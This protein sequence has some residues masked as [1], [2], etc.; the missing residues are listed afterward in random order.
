MKRDDLF[1]SL[2]DQYNTFT[3]TIQDPEAFHHDVYEISYDAD[4]S[5]EFHEMLAARRSQR[6]RELNESLESL[7]VEIIANPKLM[8]TDQ[9]QHALQ[10]FQSKSFDSMIRFF[11]SYIP[12]DYLERRH[13]GQ[14]GRPVSTTSSFSEAASLRTASTTATSVDDHIA[15][16]PC[17]LDGFGTI[18]ADFTDE[19]LD[20]NAE[21]DDYAGQEPLSPPESEMAHSEASSD[22][23]LSCGYSSTNTPS[24]SMSFSGS[25]SGMFSPELIRRSLTHDD[26]DASSRADDCETVATSIMDSIEMKHELLS[27]QETEEENEEDDEDED[28]IPTTQFPEDD[29]DTLDFYDT[30]SA[31]IPTPKQEAIAI[32]DAAQKAL[33]SQRLASPRRRSPSPKPHC[34]PHP[35]HTHRRD[36]S[37]LHG[38]RRSPEEALSKVQK[39]SP[40]VA[41]RRPVGWRRMD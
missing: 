41:R 29:F 5:T 36:G 21:A 14:H 26:D 4:T 40:D 28:D 33:A 12:E 2:H 30:P 22:D 38:I 1:T 16:S 17:S 25:E 15:C 19:P 9:W 27:R 6:L 37:P 20:F 24:R 13:H 10:L 39:P 7:A 3:Y 34:Q 31:D 11:A 32:G 35:H 8:A 23:A 18:D